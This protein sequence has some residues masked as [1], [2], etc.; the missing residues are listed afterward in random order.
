[1]LGEV[2]VYMKKLPKVS[3]DTDGKKWGRT[4]CLNFRVL[5]TDRIV[6]EFTTQIESFDGDTYACINEDQEFYARQTA[7]ASKYSSFAVNEDL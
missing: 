2:D 5:R 3:F 4:T 7:K 1:M 6:I